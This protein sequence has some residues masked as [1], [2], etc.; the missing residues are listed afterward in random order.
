MVNQV[1]RTE[2]FKTRL[3]VLMDEKGVNQTDLANRIHV[4]RQAVSRYFK[5]DVLPDIDTLCNIADCFET[6]TDYLLGNCN[7][8][9]NAD[10]LDIALNALDANA[11]KRISALMQGNADAGLRYINAL[12]NANDFYKALIYLNTAYKV[13]RLKNVEPSTQSNAYISAAKLINLTESTKEVVISGN[14]AVE[15][16]TD[17]ATRI[18]SETF[19]SMVGD[20]TELIDN[21]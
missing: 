16:Y 9:L 10:S 15:Y 19:R 11:I 8:R 2:V 4:S 14:D 20:M 13:Q 3:K 6:S 18:V 7:N 5:N 12:L 1:E 21:D 17:K